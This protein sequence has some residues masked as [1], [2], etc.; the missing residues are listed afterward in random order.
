VGVKNNIRDAQKLKDLIV[1]QIEEWP[2]ITQSMEKKI[3]SDDD[4]D[5]YD[6]YVDNSYGDYNQDFYTEESETRSIQL[7]NNERVETGPLRFIH[8]DGYEDWSGTFIR[9]DHAARHAMTLRKTIDILEDNPEFLQANCEIWMSR[10]HSL[11][12]NLEG[13]RE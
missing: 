10:L 12:S 4:Y 9:G 6:N 11:L 3:M 1:T 7:A 13:S 2:K 5:D 8:E